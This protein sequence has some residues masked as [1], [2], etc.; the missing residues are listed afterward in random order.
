MKNWIIVILACVLCGCA[1]HRQSRYFPADALTPDDARWLTQV[2]HDLDEPPLWSPSGSLLPEFY[3]AYRLTVLPSLPFA[4]CMTI[5]KGRSYDSVLRTKIYAWSYKQP[6]QPENVEIETKGLVFDES[7]ILTEPKAEAFGQ[8]F[9]A[10]DEVAEDYPPGFHGFF[11]NLDGTSI[12]L[13][14]NEFGHYRVI[15]INDPAAKPLTKEAKDMLAK[16]F[17]DLDVDNIE[18]FIQEYLKVLQWFGKESGLAILKEYE[19]LPNYTPDGIR[20]PE[21]GSPKPSR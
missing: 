18:P 2:L 11:S 20:Q 12:F 6:T 13:E 8:A 17:P 15:Q 10:L 16:V 9:R 21:D 1:T 14:A 7:R 19:E 4:V 5:H 3:T